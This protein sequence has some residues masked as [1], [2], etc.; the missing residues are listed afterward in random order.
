MKEVKGDRLKLERDGSRLDRAKGK[1]KV[2][3]ERPE[4]FKRKERERKRVEPENEVD[5]AKLR[6]CLL[7]TSPSPRDS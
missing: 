1:V 5:M 6:S 2:V 4:M 7:Y 3:P